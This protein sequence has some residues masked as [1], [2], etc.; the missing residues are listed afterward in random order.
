M[1]LSSI[2]L[3]DQL[4]GSI[5]GGMY[6]QMRAIPGVSS[7][8]KF[9]VNP[10]ITT[11]SDP[12]D[13]WE[14]GGEYI[15]DDWGTAPIIS[16]SS[17]S[18]VDNQ[19]I[20]IDGLDIEGNAVNQLI[21]LN[22]QTRVALTTPLWRVYRM[23]NEADQGG[24]INGIVYC[25]TGTANT[26]GVPADANVRAIING[27]HNQTLMALYTIPK[28]KV[29]FLFRGELGVELEGNSA[30]LAE[31]AHIHYESRRVGKVF[32]VKKAIT[33]IV[34][35]NAEHIDVRSF[36]D[37]IPELTDIKMRVIEVSMTM[38]VWGTFDILLYDIGSVPHNLQAL[39]GY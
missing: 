7:V 4:G 18:A 36:P 20:S 9:G 2:E 19:P 10:L 31:Y 16:L 3:A 29:G 1:S 5:P 22:G 12:E 37:I 11:S 26:A 30:A 24:D 39:L 15:Y 38:G 17:S 25:Y 14:F 33:N 13:I 35:G 21:T 23:E 32:K 34:G 6:V 28:G 27:E 8:D